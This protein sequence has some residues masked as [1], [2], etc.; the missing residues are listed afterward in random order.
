MKRFF[1]ILLVFSLFAGSALAADLDGLSF[2][3]LLKLQR[4]VA[5]E[6]M[7]RPEWKEVTV[8]GGTWSVGSDIPAGAYCIS[9]GKKGGYVTIKRP[10]ELFSIVSQGVRNETNK[11]GRIELRE[12]DTVEIENGSVVF[13]PAIGL[14]F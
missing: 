4:E 5:A 9:A 12:G 8:P 10:G 1:V 3:E 13:S 7:S 14:G 11:I 6:I 2:D